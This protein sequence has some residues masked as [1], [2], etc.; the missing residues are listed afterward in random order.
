MPH[1]LAALQFID[2][3]WDRT[4]LVTSQPRPPVQKQARSLPIHFTV[5]LSTIGIYIFVGLTAN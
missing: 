2:L 5:H 1:P 3:S 4:L